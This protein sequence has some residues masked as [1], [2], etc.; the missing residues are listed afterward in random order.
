MKKMLEPAMKKMLDPM[1]AGQPT[2][3]LNE[4]ELNAD[5]AHI[6]ETPDEK[7]R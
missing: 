2:G 3:E 4:D 7:L 6:P 5:L 1:W